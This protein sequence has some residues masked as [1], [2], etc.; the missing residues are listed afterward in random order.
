MLTIAEIGSNFQDLDDLMN[1]VNRLNCDVIKL[2]HYDSFMLYGYGEK[3]KACHIPW[4]W[5][6]EIS[7]ECHKVGKKLM[8]SIFDHIDVDIYKDLVD[9]FK[10][11]SSEITYL[12][13]IEA[14][15][16]TGKEIF[17]SVGGAS[18]SQISAAREIIG[19]S[20]VL[21]HCEVEYPCRTGYPWFARELGAIHKCRYGYSDH[22]TQVHMSKKIAEEIGCYAWEK[23]VKFDRFIATPDSEF[24]I[25]VTEFNAKAQCFKFNP[26]QRILKNEGW[27]R[28]L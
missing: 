28:P 26:H 23:H 15:S 17:V 6:K 22:T 20:M 3:V 18:S 27:L 19:D 13:L 7:D 8:M 1:Y 12:P 9:Y 25:S 16:R 5:A 14:M 2:Q 24:S 11:A 4:R 10:V 21:M